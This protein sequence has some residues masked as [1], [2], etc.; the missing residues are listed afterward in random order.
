MTRLTTNL[1]M[2]FDPTMMMLVD[3]SADDTVNVAT[4]LTDIARAVPDQVAVAVPRRYKD[5]RRLYGTMTFAELD[6]D[7]T[8][9][10]SGLRRMGIRRGSRLAL[11]VRPGFDFISLTFALLKAGAVS[12]LIDPGMG[13]QNVIRCLAE[14]EPEGF[15]AI[16]PVQAIRLLLRKRFPRARFNVTVGPRWFW[17][18]PSLEELRRDGGSVLPPVKTL[19]DEAAS[20][21]FTSGSTGPPKGVLYTHGNFAGQVT[22]I[23]ERFGIEP[24]GVDVAGF[25]LF[26][27]FN[28]AMGM[29]TV[30]P[31]MD[32]TR[33][34]SVDP[35][36]YIEA[37]RDWNANQSFA[38][39]AV[40]NK[41]GK[42]CCARG[43]RLHS[44]RRV[45]SAGAP[46]PVHVLQ[47]MTQI[48]HPD[49][50]VFTPYGA[51]EAL[52]VASIS[53]REVLAET[54]ARSSAGAGTCV[55]ERFPGIRWKV[56]PISD[57][58]IK[59]I[60]D[61]HSLSPGQTGEL[62]VQGAVVTRQYV[63]CTAANP[64]AKI[65][66][67]ADVWHRMGDVGYLDE[68]DRFWFCG[69]KSHRV[70]LRGGTMFTVP[71][72]AIFNRHQDIYRSALVGLGKIGSQTPCVVCEPW[73]DK[74]PQSKADQ[75]RLRAELVRLASASW[76]T[77]TIKE[78]HILFRKS[79]PVDIRH[80][81]K[82]F[83]EQLA[84][85]ASSQLGT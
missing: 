20:I 12:V 4:Q 66:D 11:M 44:L 52:P 15:I 76:L 37:V 8:V 46:V 25:P 61:V 48:I 53:A 59:S 69:R 27:L 3:R 14:V 6:H 33:P 73:P 18:G 80:N 22:E 70:R 45:L 71:C 16:P 38:S 84:E 23:R 65:A 50:D 35:L 40:W 79:L 9:I 41:V 1:K 47:W 63:T 57:Q 34:A 10:A 68:Q 5:G 24:G 62:I 64:L 17:G 30:I 60:T 2:K 56:I 82:I 67:G 77:N 83:R 51:T 26:G 36:K 75:E 29:T 43:I 32:A 28:G 58:P 13:K 7:S 54:A 81:S 74:W 31:D 39:P 72:E 49:G 19:R 21:I 85:W 42:F 55:G 78:R